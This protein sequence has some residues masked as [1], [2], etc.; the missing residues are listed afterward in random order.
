MFVQDFVQVHMCLVH[1][2]ELM[3]MFP[4]CLLHPKWHN[5]YKV[6]CFSWVQVLV[7]ITII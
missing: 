3:Y 6:H 5:D 4:K 1:F 2:I 7:I